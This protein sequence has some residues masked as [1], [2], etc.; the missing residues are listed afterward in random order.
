[1]TCGGIVKRGPRGAWFRARQGY[2]QDVRAHIDAGE[3]RFVHAP[4]QVILWTLAPRLPCL[5]R[6]VSGEAIS[7]LSIATIQAEPALY[8]GSW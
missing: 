2:F 6:G 8:P 5:Y 1:M 3:T 7:A 4:S